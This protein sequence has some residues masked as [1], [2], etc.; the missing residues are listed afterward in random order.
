MYVSRLRGE[1]FLPQGY[2]KRSRVTV[3]SVKDSTRKIKLGYT[4]L[5]SAALLS[6][7]L[8][9]YMVNQYLGTYNVV[10]KTS[11]TAEVVAV[12]LGSDA[13]VLNLSVSVFNPADKAMK[14]DRVEFDIKLNGKYMHHQMLQPIPEAGPGSYVMFSRTVVLPRDRMFTIEEAAR[15]DLWVWTVSGSGYVT[16]MFGETLL[17]FK[18]DSTCKPE[19]I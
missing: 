19:V 8:T 15:D 7:L 16:T 1:R 9:G 10:M 14:L 5:F 17:R 11:I 6:A 3:N 13:P 18:S 4:L 12:D 2:V